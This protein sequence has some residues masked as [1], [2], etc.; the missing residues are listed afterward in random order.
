MGHQVPAARQASSR[1]RS[2]P[3]RALRQVRAPADGAGERFD[4]IGARMQSASL[5]TVEVIRGTPKVFGGVAEMTDC[6]VAITA[7]EPA[8]GS[9]DV[10]MVNVKTGFNGASPADWASNVR[11]DKGNDFVESAP[12]SKVSD[13]APKDCSRVFFWVLFLPSARRNFPQRRVDLQVA[14]CLLFRFAF[15]ATRARLGVFTR[16]Y[17]KGVN[18]KVGLT[19]PTRFCLSDPEATFQA[20]S[21]DLPLRFRASRASVVVS[22]HSNSHSSKTGLGPT[23]ADK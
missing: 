12:K 3:R 21:R 23:C 20:K 18:W 8:K 19:S 14:L 2:P 22:V 13:A 17:P 15:T 5:M 6:E 7:D 11:G 16:S 4:W 10:V 9:G 1:V